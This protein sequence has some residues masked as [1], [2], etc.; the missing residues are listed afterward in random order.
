MLSLLVRAVWAVA[1][2]RLLCARATLGWRTS[3][4]Y[5]VLGALTGVVLTPLITR[6]FFPYSSGGLIASFLGSLTIQLAVLGPVLAG[7]F[8]RKTHLATSVAD[9]FLLAFITG[10]GCD[11]ASAALVASAGSNAIEAFRLFPPWQFVTSAGGVPGYAYWSGLVALA[12][13]AALRFQPRRMVALGIGA[14]ALLFVT[15]EQTALLTDAGTHSEGWARLLALTG[16]GQVTAWLAIVALAGLSTV[17]ARWARA[18]GLAAGVSAPASLWT[19][20]RA[21]AGSLA[22]LNLPEHASRSAPFRAERQRQIAAAEGR[23]RRGHRH[24]AACLL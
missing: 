16:S 1:I 23:Q 5:G 20:L 6:F 10:F 4:V 13:A 22:S 12:L 7:L 21:L 24:A 14:V 15:M 8:L 2:L 17:E 9:A 3:A 18:G 11:L 19:Q